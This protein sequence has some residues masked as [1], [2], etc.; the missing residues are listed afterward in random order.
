MPALMLLETLFRT[1]G[2]RTMLTQM[3]LTLCYVDSVSCCLIETERVYI[4]RQIWIVQ[5]CRQ[6]AN[7]GDERRV[8]SVEFNVYGQRF[9][10][11]K[12]GSTLLADE[13]VA[14]RGSM[15]FIVLHKIVFVAERFTAVE[16]GEVFGMTPKTKTLR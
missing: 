6:V 3:I 9:G 5:V 10:R 1:E 7:V 15:R 16:A 13:Q 12:A 14:R 11:V 2:L 8:S 4:K